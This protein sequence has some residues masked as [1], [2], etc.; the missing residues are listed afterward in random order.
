MNARLGE[1]D[2]EREKAAL[3]FVRKVVIHHGAVLAD[4]LKEVRKAGYSDAE[5][6][7]IVANVILNLFTNY[8]N[9]VAAT[10]LDFPAAP[11]LVDNPQDILN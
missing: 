9:M 2:C 5:I 1:S 6:S 8:F 7:E 11:Q 10:D 3:V 4:D